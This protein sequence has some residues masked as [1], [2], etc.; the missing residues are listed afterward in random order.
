MTIGNPLS[1]DMNAVLNGTALSHTAGTANVT[2]NTPGTYY[3][4]YSGTASP[5]AS[6]SSFPVSNLVTFQLNGTNIPGA[7]AQDVFSDSGQM[8]SQSLSAV[9]TV[10]TV[11]TTFRVLSSNGNFNYSNTSIN[12]IK[13]G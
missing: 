10:T 2:I 7:A 12:I 6:V 3:A 9:F 5:S 1:F 4:A 8:E 11:P 13:L